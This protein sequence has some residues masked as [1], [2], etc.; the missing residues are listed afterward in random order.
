MPAT[1]L[2]GIAAQMDVGLLFFPVALPGDDLHE[3]AARAFMTR[4][5]R[6]LAQTSRPSALRDSKAG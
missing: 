2:D 1:S 6:L 4:A 3:H 5:L